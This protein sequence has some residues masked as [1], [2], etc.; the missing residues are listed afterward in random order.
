MA[1]AVNKPL[2]SCSGHGSQENPVAMVTSRNQKGPE[3]R[4]SPRTERRHPWWVGSRDQIASISISSLDGSARCTPFRAARNVPPAVIAELNPASSIVDPTIRRPSL[5]GARIN[6]LGP[7]H[8][9]QLC[10]FVL[11]PTQRERLTFQ[12]PQREMSIPCGDR[13]DS[14]AQTPLA[15]DDGTR[16]AYARGRAP[17]R[18]SVRRRFQA[19]VTGQLLKQPSAAA[20]AALRTSV[21]MRGVSDRPGGR[22]LAGDAGRNRRP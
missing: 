17:I 21:G 1:P 18:I 15:S 20:T 14:A 8:V 4:W 6:L 19:R 16:L 3:R 2:E 13:M 10:W 7:D 9:R 12:R 11:L 22:C 5:L